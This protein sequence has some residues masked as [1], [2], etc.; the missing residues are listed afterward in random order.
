MFQISMKMLMAGAVLSSALVQQAQAEPAA[1]PATIP[2]GLTT[3]L[4]GNLALLGTQ[5]R[6]GAEFAVDE[7]NA[8]GGIAGKK[9]ALTTEDTGASSTDALN[10]MNR[11]IDGKPLVIMGSMISPHVFAQTEAV[12]KSETPF[13]VGATNAKVTSQGSK[14]LFR[15]HVHDGQLADLIP[16][17]LV[18]TLAK[19]KPGIMAVADDYG[20][21][22]SKGIQAAL[23]ELKVSPVAITSY[24]PSDKDMS[25]QL[26]EIKDKGADSLILFGRPSDITL[27]LKQMGDL[28]IKMPVIGNTSIVAQ[29]TLNNLSAAE[30]DGGYAIGGM[31]PQ[32]STDPKI[33]DWAKRVQDKHKV[34]ADNFT[35][36][37][38]DSVLLLKSIIEKVGCDKAAIRDGLAATK[39]WKGMLI[40]YQADAKGDLAH[41]LGI[42]RNKGKTPELAGNIKE[43]GF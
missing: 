41:T 24:A 7:I 5:A 38:Y 13:V 17:Y 3:P 39:D 37:Y 30:A 20:L 4:T 12:N 29:T 10:A 31:I 19:T 15:T 6:N 18:K 8:A 27:V 22:A 28:G 36:S 26:L 42:Y 32:T 25:A 16:E 14:W 40:S 43:K 35:V 2:I 11:I 1:C 33:I 9:I 23:G 21:G 34:P